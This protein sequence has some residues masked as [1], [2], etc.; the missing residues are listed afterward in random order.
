MSDPG[1]CHVLVIYEPAERYPCG[2]PTQVAEALATMPEM[3][4]HM[5]RLGE[6]AARG[7]ILLGGPASGLDGLPQGGMVVFRGLD[8]AAVAAFVAEDPV[9]RDGI[10]RARVCRFEPVPG[11]AP[12]G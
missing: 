6:A 3:A 8:T 11:L 2:T 7:E 1:L 4:V 10:E 9:V 5:A 12:P